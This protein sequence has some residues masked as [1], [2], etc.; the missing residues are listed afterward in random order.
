MPCKVIHNITFYTSPLTLNFQGILTI[1]PLMFPPLAPFLMIWLLLEFLDIAAPPPT[2][3]PAVASKAQR[4]ESKATTDD[5]KV[6]YSYRYSAKISTGRG[7]T[8]KLHPRDHRLQDEHDH[9]RME[10]RIFSEIFLYKICHNPMS[11]QYTPQVSFIF[12]IRMV[13]RVLR[14]YSHSRY[15]SNRHTRRVVTIFQHVALAPFVRDLRTKGL[16]TKP[17]IQIFRHRGHFPE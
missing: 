7:N 1:P 4:Q 16:K 12:Y 3:K 5:A 2:P 11:L 8:L 13:K 15:L 14:H 17:M 10:F 9:L 6:L